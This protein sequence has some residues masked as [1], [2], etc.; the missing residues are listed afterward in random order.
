MLGSTE[1]S[2]RIKLGVHV[3]RFWDGALAKLGQVYV[4]GEP[5]GAMVMHLDD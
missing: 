5:L 1:L 2:P 4:E 3:E